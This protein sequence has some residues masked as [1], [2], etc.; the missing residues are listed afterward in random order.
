MNLFV[1][2]EPMPAHLCGTLCLLCM[3]SDPWQFCCSHGIGRKM[4]PKMA[5]RLCCCG[6]QSR[7][8]SELKLMCYG[9]GGTISAVHGVIQHVCA[10]YAVVFSCS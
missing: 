7:C 1:G 9:S 5:A 3:V 2:S 4:A 6:V 10:R 8:M